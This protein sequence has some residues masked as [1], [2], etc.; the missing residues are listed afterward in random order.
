MCFSKQLSSFVF[1]AGEESKNGSTYL[2][3]LEHLAKQNIT[4]TDCIIALGGGVVGDLTGF[5]AATFLRGIDYVQIPTTVLSAVDSSVGGK[6]AIDLNAGKNLAGAFYQP[7]FVLCDTDTLETRPQRI[8][9]DGCAEIIKYGVLYDE[10]LFMHLYEKGAEFDIAQT[11][12][13][14]VELKKN[15]TCCCCLVTQSCLTLRLHEL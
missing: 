3:L 7:I 12:T 11:I 2:S 1:L 15:H 9:L 4:R 6:T 14:C 10:S 8:F 13:R 5:A